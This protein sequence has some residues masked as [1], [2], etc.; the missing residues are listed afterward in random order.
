MRLP[1]FASAA[2]LALAG[3]AAAQSQAP[4]CGPRLVVEYTD[5]GPDVFL[6]RNLSG[7][8]WSLDTLT[9]DL[10]GSSGDLVFDTDFGGE[11]AGS[12]STFAT[13]PGASARLLSM[14]PA[15]DGGR[16]LALR[17]SGF[18]PEGHFTVSLDVD[19]RLPN[20]ALGQTYV[21]GEEMAGARTLARFLGPTGQP[22]DVS[23]IFDTKAVAD[24]GIGG[25]V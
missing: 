6:I 9:I 7:E 12:P 22:A 19:D 14:T 2:F 8:G 11:G 24:S 16:V 13:I 1:V 5:D 23:A 18:A 17:F 20:S 21:T 4:A 3:S 10:T 15:S 25:C